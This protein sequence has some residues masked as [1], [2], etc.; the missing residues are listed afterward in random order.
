MTHRYGGVPPSGRRSDFGEGSLPVWPVHGSAPRQQPPRSRPRRPV[1]A[2]SASLEPGRSRPTG[3]SSRLPL[4]RRRLRAARVRQ[5]RAG[6]PRSRAI[7]TR[8]ISRGRLCPKG[9]ASKQLV[10]GPHRVR[11][12]LYRRPTPPS[13]RTSSS[14]RAMDMIADRVLD[15]PRRHLAGRRRTGKRCAAPSASPAS[16]ARRSTTRRTTSSRSCSP[17]WARSRSRTRR[18]YDTA[19]PSPVWG[20]RSVAAAPPPSSRTCRTPTAS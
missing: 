8:P 7:P 16:A 14:R 6:S 3:W 5:G 19:P 12:V 17:R 1:H 11:Q 10:T 18:A 20:P 15:D 2:V 9:A 4:L 13:G